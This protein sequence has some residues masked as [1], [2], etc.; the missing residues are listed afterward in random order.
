MKRIVSIIMATWFFSGLIP[1]ILLKGMAGTYG[2]IASLPL[3]YFALW[4]TEGTFGPSSY[5][6]ITSAVFAVGC[7]SVPRAE[8]WL[9]PIKDWKGKVKEHDQNQIVIDEVLGMLITC[10]P[11]VLIKCHSLWL[12]FGIAFV[13]FRFFDIVKIPPARHFD[14]E[15]NALSVMMDDVVAGVYA[16]I[17]LNLVITV[18][19]V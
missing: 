2:S 15:N 8:E 7:W 9:G 6:L 10:S 4:A 19:E 17:L 1:P 16:A 11:L 13:L 5:I 3:C 18:F 14:K 12:A